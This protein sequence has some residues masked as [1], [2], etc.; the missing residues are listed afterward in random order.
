[1]RQRTGYC[2]KINRKMS[3]GRNLDMRK[4][5][6]PQK[7][8]YKAKL[9]RGG[10]SD[11]P[12]NENAEGIVAGTPAPNICFKLARKQ[13]GW[14]WLKAIFRQVEGRFEYRTKVRSSGT[15]R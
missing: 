13:R 7:A 5:D 10:K 9:R 3:D 14:P 8:Q 15:D 6:E 1:L 4:F 11:Y 2:K 12:G